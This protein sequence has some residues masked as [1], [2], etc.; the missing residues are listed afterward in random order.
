MTGSPE[1]TTRRSRVTI[2]LGLLWVVCT[3]PVVTK[4]DNAFVFDDVLVIRNEFIHQ[5]ARIGEA[6]V[7]PTMVAQGA[8]QAR[9]LDTYRPMP[10]VTFFW[11]AAISGKE[12]WAYHVTSH[13]L[14]L[15]AT[16]AL[17]FLALE[18]LPAAGV[19]V[20]TT[21]AIA[22]GLSPQLAEAHV[23]INGRSDPLAALFGALALLTWNR[24]LKSSSVRLHTLAGFFFLLGMLSKEVLVCALPALYFWPQLQGRSLWSRAKQIVP[25]A[26]AVV[27]YMG[28]RLNALRGLRAAQDNRQIVT[29]IHNLPHL[30]ADGLVELVVPSRLY[31]RSLR[32]EYATLGTGDYAFH[33]IVVLAVLAAVVAARRRAPIALWGVAWFICTL[34]PAAMISTMFWPGFGRYLYV[35]YVGL[36]LAAGEVVLAIWRAIDPGEHGR[37]RSLRL[38]V[39]WSVISILLLSNA[40]RLHVVALQY[41]NN[42]TLFS[43]AAEEAPRPAYAFAALGAHYIEDRDFARGKFFLGK[44]VNLDP[45]DSRYFHDLVRA[46]L[47]SGNLAEAER[48]VRNGIRRAPPHVCGNLRALLIATIAGTQPEAAVDELCTCLTLQPTSFECRD[49]SRWLLSPNKPQYA[50][51]RHAMEKASQQCPSSQAREILGSALLL[52]PL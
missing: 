6:F 52:R 48:L 32:D 26:I 31:M 15:A 37:N 38:G 35:P 44:A 20:A 7:S 11:D 43:Y 41:A 5:P 25:L 4:L 1:P 49:A 22:F 21:V 42:K 29:A 45:T 3:L 17:F 18:L 9:D 10:L 27:V 19:G 39:L 51:V 2:A 36:T 33:V 47:H 14:H 30:L 34:A 8:S 16:T 24:A 50:R 12:P 13:L 46:E 23:W 40:V 28:L